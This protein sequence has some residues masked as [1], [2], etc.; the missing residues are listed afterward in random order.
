[1]ESQYD[2]FEKELQTK[3]FDAEV[4][5]PEAIWGKIEMALP[6]KS[7]KKNKLIPFIGIAA[8]LL[9]LS[10]MW[11]INTLDSDKP[12][13]LASTPNKISTPAL[14]K[15]PK[16]IIEPVKPVTQIALVKQKVKNPVS[17]EKTILLKSENVVKSDKNEIDYAKVTTYNPLV[18]LESKGFEMP[19]IAS[20]FSENTLA[21][22][23]VSTGRVEEFTIVSSNNTIN[24]SNNDQTTYANEG[25][26]T[27]GW[28]IASRVLKPI[29]S[30]ENSPINFTQED[31]ASGKKVHYRI[32]VGGLKYSGTI[33]VNN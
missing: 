18:G 6:V 24:A 26:G 27:D 25:R 1:M 3:L 10:G 19:K 5:V 12:E 23:I 16:Q 8:T 15:K 31:I 2:K 22:R 32:K 11:F 7:S 21:K 20:G 4:E 14:Q 17:D 9:L 28:D 13:V 33:H 29:T 30:L